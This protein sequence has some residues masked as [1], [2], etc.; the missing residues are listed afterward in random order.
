M[1]IIVL[2]C[3]FLLD[4]IIDVIIVIFVMINIPNNY[5]EEILTKTVNEVMTQLY[6]LLSSFRY[7]HYNTLGFFSA[8]AG[9]P[10]MELYLEIM[11]IY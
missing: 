5:L 10:Y 6:L 3:Y 9:R 4:I 11:L 8:F 7:Y 1:I 2:I